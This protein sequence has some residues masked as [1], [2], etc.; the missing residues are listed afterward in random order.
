MT[1]SGIHTAGSE[2]SESLYRPVHQLPKPCTLITIIKPNA[3]DTP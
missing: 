2:M 1:L 3:I